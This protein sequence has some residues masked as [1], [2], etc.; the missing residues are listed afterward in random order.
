MFYQKVPAARVLSSPSG[1]AAEDK[2]EE[3]ENSEVTQFFGRQGTGKGTDDGRRRRQRKDRQNFLVKYYIRY[4]WFLN[5]K[6]KNSKVLSQFSKKIWK[7]NSSFCPQCISPCFRKKN[8]VQMKTVVH[9]WPQAAAT[10]I[11][12]QST[13]C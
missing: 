8:F 7:K 3:R 5:Q 10:S 6:I 2:V 4:L 11:S 12:I 13:S 9:K 1:E